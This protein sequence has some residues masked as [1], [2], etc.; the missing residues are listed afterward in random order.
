ML[1]LAFAGGMLN[2]QATALS[3]NGAAATTSI[4][5]QIASDNELRPEARVFYLLQ[6]ADRYLHD[7][8][9][10]KV[11]AVYAQIE[12]S[13]GRMRILDRRRGMML[14]VLADSVST[15]LQ[16]V[17]TESNAKKTDENAALADTAVQK[18]LLQLDLVDD[19]FARFNTYYIASRLFEKTGNVDAM[20]KCNQLLDELFQ[21]CQSDSPIDQDRIKTATSIL[22]SMA[23]G[24]IP[25]RIPDQ[26]YFV[27]PTIKPFTEQDF[28][29][30]EKL[31]RRAIALV[32]RLDPTEHLRR[33][34]HRDLTLWYMQLGKTEQAEREKQILFELPG[35]FNT[36]AP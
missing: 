14:E 1:A 16:S 29:E 3:Q 30:S 5:Q 4:I 33:K 13:P 18:A 12:A 2:S 17:K 34:E 23:Y 27:P 10:A 24:F 7:G 31:K 20:K 36:A 9:R 15:P 35:S 6:L 32:D 26:S 11:E 21:S 19:N 22:N 25:V 28:E 8:D